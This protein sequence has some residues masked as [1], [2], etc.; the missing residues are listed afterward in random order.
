MAIVPTGGTA[1]TTP[2]FRRAL[3]ER[4]VWADGTRSQQA[5]TRSGT[6]SRNVRHRSSPRGESWQPCGPGITEAATARVPSLFASCCGRLGYRPTL[7]T[8]RLE[9]RAG[10]QP[11][12][13]QDS[14]SSRCRSLT[15]STSGSGKCAEASD[16]SRLC[17]PP[18][19]INRSGCRSRR[20]IITAA[21]PATSSAVMTPITAARTCACRTAVT[22]DLMGTSGPR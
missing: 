14:C 4:A 3:S 9:R 17:L 13:D 18:I 6:T 7:T 19:A 11:R 5:W 12:V 8:R 16:S 2:S 15:A 22:H 1:P 20:A 21:A 10:P